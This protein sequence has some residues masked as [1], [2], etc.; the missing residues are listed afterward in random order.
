MTY[1]SWSSDFVIS[2]RLLCCSGDTDSVWHKH[3]TV[4]IYVGQWPIFHGPVISPYILKTIWW[5]N[6]IIGILDPCDAKIYH[7]KCM[8]VSR[9]WATYCQCHQ[10]RRKIIFGTKNIIWRKQVAKI[11][12]P[13]KKIATEISHINKLQCTEY[14]S[15]NYFNPLIY[16]P[17]LLIVNH[18]DAHKD[19]KFK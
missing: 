18:P 8:W 12:S 7:V 6:V 3:C 1:I 19:L 9:V 5:T 10:M 14:L 2:W 4:T 16:L 15:N 17:V 11:N 13:H